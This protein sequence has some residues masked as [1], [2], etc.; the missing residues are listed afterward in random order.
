MASKPRRNTRRYPEGRPRV[1]GGGGGLR[2]QPASRPRSRPNYG[3]PNLPP[4]L[5]QSILASIAQQQPFP[6]ASSINTTP[7]PLSGGTGGYDVNSDPAVAAAQGL[8][9]KIRA[10]AQASA[11]AKR[12]QAALEYGDPTGVEGVDEATAKA[13]RENPF[14]I[15]KNMEHAYGTGRR[16]LEEG[17]NKANLF[18]SGYRG[19]QL[20]EAARA[21]EQNRYQ[22]G[23]QFK[24]LMTDIGD[25]LANALLNADMYEQ[26]ALLNSSGGAYGGGGGDGG[27]GGEDYGPND[28][29][30]APGQYGNLGMFLPPSYQAPPLP[31]VKRPITPSMI[32]KAL[33]PPKPPPKKKMSYGGGG[34]VF[35]SM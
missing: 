17:L 6:A 18:Y 10:N 16:D 24:G 13:A 20:G 5:G 7:A 19:Q 31:T 9:A 23:T 15:L 1:G 30:T 22:A 11:L 27:G 35:R 34:G 25:Q 21:Y 28:D 4:G 3:I 26:N 2:A 33:T 32:Q 29:G 12:K 14:S 8:A